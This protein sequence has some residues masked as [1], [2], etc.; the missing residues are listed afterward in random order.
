MNELN[1]RK[2]TLDFGIRKTGLFGSDLKQKR[3]SLWDLED[4]NL[5]LVHKSN[6][7]QE[8][9]SYVIS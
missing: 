5:Q 3:E 6:T 9:I 4:F 7:A 1:V 8:E 2:E